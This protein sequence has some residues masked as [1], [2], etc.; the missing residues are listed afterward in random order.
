MRAASD[1][2]CVVDRSG[3]TIGSP[4]ATGLISRLDR[5]ASRCE[6]SEMSLTVLMML[7]LSFVV[8]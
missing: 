5:F 1:S 2:R 7:L 6:R 4:P 8:V 3:P